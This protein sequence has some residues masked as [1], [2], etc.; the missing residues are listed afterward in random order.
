M[1]DDEYLRDTVNGLV[2]EI[3]F[4][5]N[6]LSEL[7]KAVEQL[8]DVKDPSIT[9]LETEMNDDRTILYNL[10]AE[11]IH[12]T[13]KLDMLL[14]QAKFINEAE[15]KYSMLEIKLNFIMEKLGL[16]STEKKELMK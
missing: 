2:S 11:I 5:K 8:A 1:A 12:N 3:D 7:Y 10:Q 15:R 9:R 13:E 14:N 4:I 16:K 6:S